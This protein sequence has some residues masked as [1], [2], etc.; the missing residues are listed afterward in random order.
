MNSDQFNR[1]LEYL[2]LKQSD[3]AA[4]LRVTPRAV[5]RWQSGEQPLPANVV[6]LLNA[7]K[8]LHDKHIPWGP[9]LEAIWPG[10]DDQIRRKEHHDKALAELLKRV[11]VRG[12]LAAPWRVNL[13]E[14]SATLGRI[15]V[16]F[17]KL[18]GGGFSLANYRRGD[19]DSDA[20]RDRILI[21]DAVAAFSEAVGNAKEE[22]P[23]RDWDE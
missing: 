18:Q 10:D 20:E 23:D 22:R 6:E 11:A 16:G 12:G 9:A 8:Q 14:H 5:R 15:D 4:L 17:Y 3:A 2:G 7:W 1:R 19:R 13:K 21:E